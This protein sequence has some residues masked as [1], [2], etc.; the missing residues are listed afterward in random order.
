MT[1]EGKVKAKV[2]TVLKRAGAYYHM[3]VQNGLGAPSLDFV[4]CHVGKFFAIETKAGKKDMTERQKQTSA[5]M[6]G[7]GATVFLVNEEYGLAE[8]EQWLQ[9]NKDAIQ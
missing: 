2:K 6:T 4:G 9:E 7:A 8:L 3:V 5:E 1:P